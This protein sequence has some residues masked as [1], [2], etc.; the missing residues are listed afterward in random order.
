MYF[1]VRVVGFEG[2]DWIHLAQ[3]ANRWQVRL[4]TVMNLLF[5]QVKNSL[6]N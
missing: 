5:P 3:D 2:V 6:N 1:T 4:N